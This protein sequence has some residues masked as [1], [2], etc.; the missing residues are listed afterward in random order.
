MWEASGHVEVFSDPLVE[1][2][3]CHKRYRA[4][5]L[6]EAYEEKNGRPPENGLAD[7]V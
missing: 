5:H 7:I 3:H 6:L 4:D 1:S 2:L